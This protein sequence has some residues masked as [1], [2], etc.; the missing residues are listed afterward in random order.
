VAAAA[1][2]AAAVAVAGT[3]TNFD[4]GSHMHKVVIVPFLMFI[5]A[6]LC[7]HFKKQIH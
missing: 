5:Q 3:A 6:K 2:A 4:Q 1:A 7:A